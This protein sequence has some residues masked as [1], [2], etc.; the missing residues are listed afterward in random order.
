MDYL[1]ILQKQKEEALALFDKNKGIAKDFM[2]KNNISRVVIEFDGNGDSGQVDS[3]SFQDEN[4][5]DTDVNHT[6]CQMFERTARWFGEEHSR[7]LVE[8]TSNA[9]ALFI[10]MAYSML[11]A[12]HSGWEI[13]EGSFGAIII[14]ADGTGVMEYNERVEAVNTS[15]D[16][17]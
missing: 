17:F 2:L 8:V 9:E 11:E 7:E 14:K 15:V 13:N 4:E 5:E 6:P 10:E 12:K 3:V 16:L 1:Q